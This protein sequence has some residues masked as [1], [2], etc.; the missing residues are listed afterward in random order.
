MIE[1]D[2]EK[3]SQASLEIVREFFIANGFFVL[4]NEDILFVKNSCLKEDTVSERFVLSIEEIN[5]INNAVIKVISWHTMKFTP[6]VLN[7]NPEIFEFLVDSNL[8]TA[9]KVFLGDPFLKILL[10][11]ALPA[12]EDLKGKSIAIMKDKGIDHIITFP[13]IVSGLIEKIESRHV[14]LSS[15]NEVLRILKFYRFF[16]EEEQ[17]LPF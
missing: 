3:M 17:N 5:Q 8:Q 14:Y 10:L 7:K 6:S 4:K 12:S 1:E 2:E 15:V 11:P 9:G 13:S 16:N